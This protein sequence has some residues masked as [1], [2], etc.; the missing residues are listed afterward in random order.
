MS[1]VSQ[2]AAGGFK[3]AIIDELENQINKERWIPVQLKPLSDL[4]DF[5]KSKFP[6]FF[7][8]VRLN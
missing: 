3:P 7:Q 1:V 8:F 5:S 6:C 2:S 4:E